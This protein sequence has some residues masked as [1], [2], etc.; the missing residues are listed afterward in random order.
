MGA[1]GGD[2]QRWTLRALLR[3]RRWGC[4]KPWKWCGCR[5]EGHEI[6]QNLESTSRQF[7]TPTR[8]LV[9]RVE[10]GSAS[11]SKFL[12]RF[13]GQRAPGPDPRPIRPSFA[14]LLSRSEARLIFLPG[15]PHDDPT[16]PPCGLHYPANGL[17]VVVFLGPS[18]L[19]SPR[20]CSSP[21]ACLIASPPLGPGPR[22]SVLFPSGERGPDQVVE[23]KRERTKVA[24]TAYWKR[25][26]LWG[27]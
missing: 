1:V 2:H 16:L 19:S 21:A 3:A 8:K 6:P 25:G 22:L 9:K 15:E 27:K 23:A 12:F 14:T 10:R 24:P 4:W 13:P 11:F 17:V 7:R 20:F 26:F 5:W 18:L